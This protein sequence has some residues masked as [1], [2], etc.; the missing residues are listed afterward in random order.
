[1]H[2]SPRTVEAYIEIM[3]N[4]FDCYSKYELIEKCIKENLL[5]SL[6]FNLHL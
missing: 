4:K 6:L 1:M 3:K 5:Y 2:T